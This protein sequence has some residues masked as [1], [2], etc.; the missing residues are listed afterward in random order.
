MPCINKDGAPLKKIVWID[1]CSC[2]CC[3]VDG[4]YTILGV[5]LYT[6]SMIKGS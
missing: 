6:R 4:D 1:T 2:K 5:A 3:S